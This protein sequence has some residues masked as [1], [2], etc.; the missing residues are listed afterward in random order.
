MDVSGNDENLNVVVESEEDVIEESEEDVLEG[1]ENEENQSETVTYVSYDY[2]SYFED[3]N[4]TLKFQTAVI[5]G[6]LLL[7]GFIV[8]WKK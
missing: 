2:T 6:F 7:V 3:I 4:T 5:I 1:S 8:G